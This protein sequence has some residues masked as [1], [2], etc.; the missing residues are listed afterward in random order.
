MLAEI[1][2]ETVHYLV[3]Y[4]QCTRHGALEVAL[5]LYFLLTELRTQRKRGSTVNVFWGNPAPS[6]TLVS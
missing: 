3:H 4:I 1:H 6:L 2:K 5:H